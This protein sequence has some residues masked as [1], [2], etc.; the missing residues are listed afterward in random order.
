M[1]NTL[2]A[3]HFLHVKNSALAALMHKTKD[4][5][6][7]IMNEMSCKTSHICFLRAFSLSC[8][9][10]TQGGHEPHRLHLAGSTDQACKDYNTNAHTPRST[11]ITG[12]LCSK[13]IL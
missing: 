7:M 12:F 3:F 8:F 11:D 10:M 2:V 1:R 5:W 4:E 13:F 6:R 9:C